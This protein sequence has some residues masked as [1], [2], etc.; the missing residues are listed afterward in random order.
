MGTHRLKA[1][2]LIQGP[3]LTQAK[4]TQSDLF[5]TSLQRKEYC[6]ALFATMLKATDPSRQFAVRLSYGANHSTA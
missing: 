3:S 5:I 2:I 6:Q 1:A 4:M